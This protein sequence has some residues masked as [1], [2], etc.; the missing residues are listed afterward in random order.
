MSD[1]PPLPPGIL[2]NVFDTDAPPLNPATVIDTEAGRVYVDEKPEGA[3]PANVDVPMVSQEGLELHCTMGNWEGEPDA[4]S[5]QW[6]IDGSDVGQDED[7]LTVSD[8]DTGRTATCTVIASNAYGS[9]IAPVSNE[10]IIEGEAPPA[11][12]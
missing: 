11:A 4:Y 2:P 12:A 7:V 8:H 3:P 6:Q 5:Y 1:K 9:T 10:L